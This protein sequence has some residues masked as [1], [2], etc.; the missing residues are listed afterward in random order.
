MQPPLRVLSHTTASTAGDVRPHPR[1]LPPPH[2]EKHVLQTPGHAVSII[3]NAIR[4]HKACPLY[5]DAEAAEHTVRTGMPAWFPRCRNTTKPDIIM[6][7]YIPL[8]EPTLNTWT[9]PQH[10]PPENRVVWLIELG[11]STDRRV[12]E[13]LQDKL[14][15]HHRYAQQLRAAGWQT[16]IIP[17]VLTY[18]ALMTSTLPWLLNEIGQTEYEA[19]ATKG[20]LMKL[21][22]EYNS[23]LLRTR[24]KL[25]AMQNPPDPG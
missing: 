23:K 3:G 8:F 24:T 13:K 1:R 25:R 5:M 4:R 14:Q 16:R 11:Y 6:M 22:A 17:V 10:V 19:H 20:L 12:G 7:P 2:N 9:T 15:Q 18:S 21:T